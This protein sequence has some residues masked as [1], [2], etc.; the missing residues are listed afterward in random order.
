MVTSKEVISD[1]T[2]STM[3]I[4]ARLMDIIDNELGMSLKKVSKELGYRNQS[5]L[6]KVKNGE[7]FLGHEKLARFAQL[8]TSTGAQ[9]NLNWILTGE[10][11]KMTWNEKDISRAIQIIDLLGQSRLKTLLRLVS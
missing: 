6:T 8:K 1:S 3:A 4:C 7:G 11:P 2:D 5:P 10:G 9:P